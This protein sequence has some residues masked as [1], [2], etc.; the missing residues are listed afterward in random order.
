[1][2]QT[3]KEILQIIFDHD[4][5]RDMFD[6]AKLAAKEAFAT[7]YKEGAFRALYKAYEFSDLNK[8]FT[9]KSLISDIEHID[10]NIFKECAKALLVP[11]NVC[12]Y[13]VGNTSNLNLNNLALSK[14]DL[15]DSHS[16]RIAGFNYDPLLRQ[17][18][19]ITSIARDDHCTI[20]EAFDFLNPNITNLAKLLIVEILAE[21][22]QTHYADIWVDSL[23][24]SVIFSSEQVRSYKNNCFDCTEKS[25][26]AAQKGLLGK[27]ISLLEKN[28]EHFAIKAASQMTIGVYVDQYLSFLSQCTYEM[29]KE[30]CVT[31]D[32]KISEAQIV[33]RKES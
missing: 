30:V 23:D 16:V 14:S 8:R 5:N 1:M 24:A 22:I 21:H 32:Y 6:Q 11:G 28:P 2:L 4:Y 3:I 13:I 26:I 12:M 7:R 27:Y 31:A 29:F 9:L 15:A 10:F 17:D 20:I 25:Y 18:A 19:H 33:L